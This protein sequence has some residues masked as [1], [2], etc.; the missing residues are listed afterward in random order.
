MSHPLA[1]LLLAGLSL[2]ASAQVPGD[3]L[4]APRGTLHAG[5]IADVAATGS[6][7]D[8]AEGNEMVDTVAAGMRYGSAPVRAAME[9]LREVETRRRR[10]YYDYLLTRGPQ[11]E[12]FEQHLDRYGLLARTSAPATAEQLDLLEERAGMPLP[13]QL[14]GFYG[15]HGG[16]RLGSIGGQAFDLPAPGQLLRR[17]D[18]ASGWERLDSLGLIDMA[19]ASWGHD[20]SELEA[21]GGVF[22]EAEIRRANVELRCVGWFA[23]EEGEA[24]A[25]LCFDRGQRLVLAH[26][27]QDDVDAFKSAIAALLA[28]EGVAVSLSELLVEKLEQTVAGLLRLEEEDGDGGE[29]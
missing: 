7:M 2:S 5:G 24:F 15:E 13:A 14:R 1:V 4:S 16:M 21:S 23:V 3:A 6:A 8:S 28:G 29:G 18:L 26:Y 20:R 19:R 22:T 12:T 11:T 9:R 27:H 25:Y 17:L 10:S